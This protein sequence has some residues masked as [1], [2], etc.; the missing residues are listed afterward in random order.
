MC[1]RKNKKNTQR[2]SSRV[3]PGNTFFQGVEIDAIELVLVRLGN[4]LLEVVE[5]RG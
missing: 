2:R 1:G 4:N 3:R 5:I